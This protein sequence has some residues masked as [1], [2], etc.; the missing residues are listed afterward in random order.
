MLMTIKSDDDSNDDND[1]NYDDI[2]FHIDGARN[3]SAN[4]AAFFVP[5]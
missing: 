2:A 5:G 1:F 4:F 3:L